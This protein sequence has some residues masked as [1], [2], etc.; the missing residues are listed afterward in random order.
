VRVFLL[1][2]PAHQ[3]AVLMHLHHALGDGLGWQDGN[4]PSRPDFFGGSSV[5]KIPQL[6]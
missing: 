6:G 1:R 2:T 4:K 5:R 3:S